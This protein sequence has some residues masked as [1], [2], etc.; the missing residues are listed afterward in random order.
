MAKPDKVLMAMNEELKKLKTEKNSKLYI[1]I[2]I[3]R[4]NGPN[5]S[6]DQKIRAGGGHW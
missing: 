1:Y 5:Q 4:I 3:Y 2:Y 6:G